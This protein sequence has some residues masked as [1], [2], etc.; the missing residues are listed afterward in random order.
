[1]N[2]KIFA[3]PV[4]VAQALSAD[5]FALSNADEP[6]HISLSGGSTPGIWFTTLALP[7]WAR[8]IRWENLHF[9]WS[10]ERCVPPESAESNFGT[11]NELLFRH[12]DIPQQNLHRIHGEEPPEKEALRY[13]EEITDFVRT[14]KEGVPVFDWIHLGMGEDGHTA[15]LFPGHT[16]YDASQLVITTRHP[17][18]GQDRISK[19]ARLLSAGERVSYLVLNRK[20]AALLGKI[21]EAEK[22]KG[23]SAALPW[24]AAR[25]GSEHGVTEWYL[26][27]AAASLL[28][29]TSMNS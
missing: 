20:K 10:D 5:L 6:K 9:W 16:D 1:M 7:V 12:I 15:S 27:L 28:T 2:W 19:T 8:K 23:S 21:Q 17:K 14:N 24:P 25:I 4:L 29:D 11:A 22:Q 3:S 18:S 26:D 13:A